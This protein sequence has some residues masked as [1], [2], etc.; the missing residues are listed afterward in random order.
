MEVIFA[1]L[2]LFVGGVMNAVADRI[3]PLD[4]EYDGPFVSDSVR[5]LK[6]WEYLPFLSFVSASQ[7][8]RMKVAN[9]AW[10]Y[11]V[12]EIATALASWLRHVSATTLR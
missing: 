4:P 5:P 10:R 11:P 1:I 6:W 9:G 7:A 12:L 3:P 2:G 8:P